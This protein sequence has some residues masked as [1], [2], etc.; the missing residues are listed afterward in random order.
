MT[1]KLTITQKPTYLH[2]TITGENTKDNVVRYLDE[3]LGEC[4]ARGCFRA[5]IEERLEGPRLRT[6]DVFE[7]VSLGSR[8]ALGMLTALAYVDMHAEGDLMHFAET[9]ALNRGVPIMVFSDLAEAEKWLLGTAHK[10]RKPAG[11]AK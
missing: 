2:A 7:I 1:Y 11:E 9:S 10:T 6:L 8:R 4:V 3:L 5:L